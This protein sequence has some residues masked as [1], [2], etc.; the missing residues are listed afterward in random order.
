MVGL[1]YNTQILGVLQSRIFILVERPGLTLEFHFLR[2][3]GAT[4]LVSTSDV[5]SLKAT[6]FMYMIRAPFLM[7]PTTNAG[8]AR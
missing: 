5:N 3:N 4:T 6:Y 8:I 7:I 2:R 1:I